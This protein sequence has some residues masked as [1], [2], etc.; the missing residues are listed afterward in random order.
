[1]YLWVGR[2]E[3]NKE[4]DPSEASRLISQYPSNWVAALLTRS[5]LVTYWALGSNTKSS[6]L[7]ESC[8]DRNKPSAKNRKKA[9]SWI[10]GTFYLPLPS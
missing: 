6:P 9:N 10:A 2:L 8:L 7:K 4:D 1:M 5:V 3:H